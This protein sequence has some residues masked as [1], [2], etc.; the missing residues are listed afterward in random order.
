MAVLG[1]HPLITVVILF[2][3]FFTIF[4]LLIYGSLHYIEGRKSGK[5]SDSED[6]LRQGNE[7]PTFANTKTCPNCGTAIPGIAEFCP[8]CGNP[9]IAA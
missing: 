2:V 6:G 3:V 8:E 4:F 5:T 7:I 1:P 9:Q